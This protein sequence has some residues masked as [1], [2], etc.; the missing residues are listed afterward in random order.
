M[1][2]KKAAPKHWP[3]PYRDAWDALEEMDL[4]F[5]ACHARMDKAVAKAVKVIKS[6]KEK[7]A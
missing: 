7:E 6:L 3:K 2:K 5:T 1:R 4:E